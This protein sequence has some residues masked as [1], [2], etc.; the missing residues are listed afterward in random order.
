MEEFRAVCH[1]NGYP[2]GWEK[3]GLNNVSLMSASAVSGNISDEMS[4]AISASNHLMGQGNLNKMDALIY[5]F[6]WLDRWSESVAP[7]RQKRKKVEG[8]D[9]RGYK[10]AEQKQAFHESLSYAVHLQCLCDLSADTDKN[11][12]YLIR[13][14]K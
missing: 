3:M 1:S 11:F 4:P 7:G 2:C 9:E 8:E 12:N 13:E 6:F 5:F 10:Q 14:G